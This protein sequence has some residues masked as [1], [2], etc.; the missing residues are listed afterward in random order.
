MPEIKHDFSAGKM[1]K[2][3]DERIVPNGQYRDAMNIQVRTTSGDSNG[4]GDAGTAQN[5]LGNIPVLEEIHYEY[6][7]VEPF[8]ENE[9]KFIGSISNEKDN[10]AYFFVASPSFVDMYKDVTSSSENVTGQKLFIDTIAE[11]SSDQNECL[12]VACDVW[13][14]V[15]KKD[16]I[17]AN[18]PVVAG[19]LGEDT[20]TKFYLND[21]TSFGYADGGPVRIGMQIRAY[22]EYTDNNGQIAQGT[23]F[24][25]AVVTNI[26]DTA[27]TISPA[28]ENINWNEVYALSFIHP[29]RVLNFNRNNYISSINIVDDLLFW[30]DNQS[31]TATSPYIGEPKKIN[32]KRCKRGTNSFTSHT[33]LMLNDPEDSDNLLYY[34]DDY[35][36]PNDDA[37]ENF[38]ELSVTPAANNDLKL[39]HV[40]VIR[41]APLM[42]PTIHMR[43]SDREGETSAPNFTF[44]FEAGDWNGTG[45]TSTIEPGI[46]LQIP[47]AYDVDGDL[48]TVGE[49]NIPNIFNDVYWKVNDIIIFREQT[50]LEENRLSATIEDITWTGGEEGEGYKVITIK[51]LTVG[52]IDPVIS[53]NNGSGV[54]T[55][56]LEQ[57]DPLFELKFG[58]FGLRYKYVDGEY[59][60]FGP[61][62][63]IAFI[64]GPFD[65]VHEKG[66]NLGMVNHMRELVIKDFIPHQRIRPADMIAVDVLY[67]TTESP[68]VYV[69]KT[70]TK[71]RSEEWDMFTTQPG[72]N[73]DLVFGELKVTSEM[74]YKALPELQLLRAWDNVP[75]AALGQEIASNR[76]VYANYDQGYEIV[77]RPALKQSLKNF[78]DPTPQYPKKSIKSIREYKFGMVF[79]DKFGRE[80]PVISPGHVE[81]IKEGIF[82]PVD[83]SIQVKKL[84]S[85]KRN[86]F[87]LSQ[88]WGKGG[89]YDSFP[90]NW[91]EYV[92]YY[93]KETSN[94]YYNLV[95]DRWYYAEDGNIW[96]SFQSADRNKVDEETYLIL[97]NKHGSEEAVYER[98]RYKILAIKNEAPDFIKT[99]Y[100]TMGDVSLM[101]GQALS[102]MFTQNNPG[103]A[104]AE[105][106]AATELETSQEIVIDNADWDDFLGNYEPD[107]SKTLQI[108]ITANVGGETGTT[109][110]TNSWKS[111][112]YYNLNSANDADVRWDEAFGQDADMWDRLEQQGLSAPMTG[113]EYRMEFREAVV[114]NKPE[115]DGKFFVK[116]EKDDVLDSNILL[117]TSEMADWEVTLTAPVAYIENT[118]YNPSSVT[119]TYADDTYMPRRGYKW[120]TTSGTES[121][122]GET[123]NIGA[124]SVTG[125]G[126]NNIWNFSNVDWDGVDYCSTT[127]GDGCQPRDAEFLGLG[128]AR[129]GEGDDCQDNQIIDCGED[130]TQSNVIN[131]ANISARYWGF[132]QDEATNSNFSSGH[133]AKVFIDG[134]R[135]R[136]TNIVGSGSTVVPADCETCGLNNTAVWPGSYYKQTGI[137]EGI[138][139]DPN[140]TLPYQATINGELGRMV[141]S[142]MGNDWG[143]SNLDP[144]KVRSAIISNAIFKFDDDPEE[145][146]RYKIVGSVDEYEM[147]S[148]NQAINTQYCA[149]FN[150]S[151]TNYGG[152]NPWWRW[153]DFTN[154]NPSRNMYSAGMTDTGAGYAD[155]ESSF[156]KL[157][158]VTNTGAI[159]DETFHCLPCTIGSETDCAGSLQ[160]YTGKNAC[161]RRGIR[162]EFRKMDGEALQD[163][164]E[165]G[166]NTAIWDP[167][168]SICHDGREALRI[169]FLTP[170]VVLSETVIPVAN[171]AVWETEPKEDVGLDIYYEASN[172]I[173][174]RLNSKNTLNFVPYNCKVAKKKFENGAYSNE[175][176]DIDWGVA[177][178]PDNTPILGPQQAQQA[179]LQWGLGWGSSSYDHHV[180][181]VG[182]TKT[183]S[184][185]GIK[186]RKF[187]EG[188]IGSAWSEDYTLQLSSLQ[189]GDY[190]TFEHSNGLIT[191]SKIV[192]HMQ[193]V[194]PTYG[195]GLDPTAVYDQYGT[196]Q[197]Y[198]YS[199]DLINNTTE[200]AFVEITDGDGIPVEPG[201]P[202]AS[203]INP[204]GFFKIDSEV[205]KFPI[206]LNWWN[207]ISFGNGVESDRIRDDYNQ[208]TIDNGVKVS[209]TFL[210]YGRERRRSG[211]I[212]SG[213]YNSTSG[214]NDLNEFNMADKITKDINPSYGSIQRLKTRDTDMVILTEDKTLR[215]VT[216]KDALYNADG[217]PQLMASNRVL[218]TAVPF[219][220]DYGISQNPESLAWDQYRLYYTDKQRGAVIRLSKD[221]LTPI[222]NVGMRSWFRDQFKKTQTVLGTFDTINGE[223]NLTFNEATSNPKT[224][225][226]NEEGKGWVSFKSFY[227]QTGLSV[228]GKYF[229]AISKDIGDKKKIKKGIWEHHIDVVKADSSASNFEEII[230]RNVFYASYDTIQCEGSSSDNCE[231][232]PVISN[233]Y[234]ESTLNILFNDTPNI[235]KSFKTINYEGS[236]ARVQRFV[237]SNTTQPNGQ[238]F[239]GETDNEYYNL[240]PKDGWWVNNITTDLTPFGYANSF[241]KKEGKWYQYIRGERT[242]II[243]NHLNEFS[244]QGLGTVMPAPDT[245]EEASGNITVV[246]ENLDDNE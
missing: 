8:G 1:N 115:F 25:G 114:K 244:V 58:R 170:T 145:N 151:T 206:E 163:G 173:P 180:F 87:E 157:G 183:N 120:L 75:R 192:S 6:P 184:I 100:N 237:D 187:T 47:S 127:A 172:A 39:E 128:C 15:D 70:I 86:K 212:Y 196:L 110:R 107:A 10:K 175:V 152:G 111:L 138:Q 54:W 42:A 81:E 133:G 48:N 189:I 101:G 229:T 213:I 19:M 60:N 103:Q 76:L 191:M 137:D 167:R 57:P 7:Y 245:T 171:A 221:G 193:P 61:W 195:V 18:I 240:E 230:N 186:S 4:E 112:T 188:D 109:V 122:N 142:T 66:Y 121:F 16:N 130:D 216:N 176:I 165:R 178:T 181:Y 64:P 90:D 94:E 55:I 72:S 3:L 147:R 232:I 28:Q 92:K 40:T 43:T 11:V 144:Y 12:P 166:I 197:G 235:V 131:R 30:T 68:N 34:V 234:S 200:A 116:V 149:T 190:L 21:D 220:G 241:K 52:N 51:I 160:N 27:V 174:M 177:L 36:D 226:F 215:V 31:P 134:A 159:Q 80:T 97:K 65:Y 17:L 208:N 33:Q 79:G 35:N 222:S 218:G 62:S 102:Y 9:S 29:E 69:V 67:K 59:S 119:A 146:N 22:Y 99:V 182:Y 219:S 83:D 185:V 153:M 106:Y 44:N 143:P 53:G 205:W 204:T 38:S 63:E 96:L 154:I 113:I 140:A 20:F 26:D 2:D 45:V 77:N 93:I 162:F 169:S 41:R 141:I 74:I 161:A 73:E 179:G 217:N 50:G 199:D 117:L 84:F 243:D 214:I 91:I 24:D 49:N 78:P 202:G 98:G 124:T 136:R 227:P 95:M 242:G 89:Q 118:E 239:I 56:E 46:T 14:V 104:T 211:M 132:F 37:I 233:Y 209:S 231:N 5:V 150:G 201:S 228:G 203:A 223:Y 135:T 71:G 156:I 32:I 129:G 236:Q 88:L 126:N 125:S 198:N 225:S 139:S 168:G 108:A 148:F 238:S 224:L 23:Y 246:L 13:G 207:C 210:D 123:I 105:N 82:S 164:G 155:G 194:D 85:D 158:G